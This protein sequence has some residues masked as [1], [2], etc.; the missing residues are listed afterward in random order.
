M[1]K[2]SARTYVAADE[3]GKLCLIPI[4]RYVGAARWAEANYAIVGLST[5]SLAD[6]EDLAR[7]DKALLPYIREAIEDLFEDHGFMELGEW[8]P[9]AVWRQLAEDGVTDEDDDMPPN[10]RLSEDKANSFAVAVGDSFFES[11]GLRAEFWADELP[12]SIVEQYGKLSGGMFGDYFGFDWQDEP[13]I[14][15]ALEALGHEVVRWTDIE[16]G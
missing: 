13:K 16:L 2:E 7:G 9:E 15:S 8:K 12:S 5:V 3:F 14:V 4:E 10:W 6:A 11:S 1:T